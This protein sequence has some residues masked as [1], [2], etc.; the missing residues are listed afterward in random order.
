MIL[1]TLV[2]ITLQPFDLDLRSLW[3]AIKELYLANEMQ[4]SACCNDDLR[5][6]C[7]SM[8]LLPDDSGL[9]VL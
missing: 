8:Q 1:L 5:H 4:L 6:P 2:F 9:V 7:R 3:N